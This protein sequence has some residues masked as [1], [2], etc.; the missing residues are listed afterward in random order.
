VELTVNPLLVE[1]I[2]WAFT[3]MSSVTDAKP[4]EF[5]ANDPAAISAAWSVVTVLVDELLS[6]L[7]E[8]AP[9]INKT[10]NDNLNVF[11]T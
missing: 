8:K 3:A 5:S 9:S 7:H 6:F 11:I 2:P 1:L 10:I 4:S